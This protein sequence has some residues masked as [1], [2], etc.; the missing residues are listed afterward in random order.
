MKTIKKI[1]SFT[2]VAIYFLLTTK[3][4]ISLHLHLKM[5][6]K[7]QNNITVMLPKQQPRYNDHIIRKN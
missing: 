5:N 4:Y 7:S 6:E 3:F 1:V 2:L